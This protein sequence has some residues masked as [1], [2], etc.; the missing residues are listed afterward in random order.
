MLCKP[1]YCWKRSE[2]LRTLQLLTVFPECT[3]ASPFPFPLCSGI[4]YHLGGFIT[5]MDFFMYCDHGSSQSPFVY[6][7][8]DI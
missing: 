5:R 1:F 8:E 3:I 2:A 4:R 6:P 7:N